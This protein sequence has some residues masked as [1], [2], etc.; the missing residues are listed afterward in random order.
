MHM[1]EACSIY[2]KPF[3]CTFARSRRFGLQR[4]RLGRSGYGDSPLAIASES[5][6][7]VVERIESRAPKA[8]GFGSV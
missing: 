3:R 4:E 2:P 8:E 6:A 7:V 1:R 5:W